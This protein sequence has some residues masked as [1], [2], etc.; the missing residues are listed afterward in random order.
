MRNATL[1]AKRAARSAV[2]QVRVGFTESASFNALVTSTF[3]NFPSAFPD[4]EVSL[5]ERQSTELAVALREGRIDVAFVRP[6]LKTAEGLTLRLFQEEEMVA[7]VP[8][9]HALAKR[10]RI[11]LRELENEA[12]I[13]YPRAVRPGLADAVVMACQ[14]AGFTPRV[15]QYAPQLAATINRC[16]LTRRFGSAPEHAGTAAERARLCSFARPAGPRAD[17]AAVN[18]NVNSRVTHAGAYTV[19]ANRAP[20]TCDTL[21]LE[22]LR[23]RPDPA[24]SS[25]CP[26]LDSTRCAPVLRRQWPVLRCG[27]ETLLRRLK[28]MWVSARLGPVPRN[29]ARRRGVLAV[30]CISRSETVVHNIGNV[31]IAAVGE[32]SIE[33]GSYRETTSQKR[34]TVSRPV[35]SFQ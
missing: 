20:H 19:G 18:N 12:F 28:R 1:I 35:G 25:H 29:D 6:P 24:S 8:S 32:I 23:T 4:I 16:R 14:K 17:D 7:A 11:E 10:K 30:R 33:F 31:H 9:G 5:V 3:R 22:V 21:T 15:E 2:G 34:L 26:T 27:P 13:L